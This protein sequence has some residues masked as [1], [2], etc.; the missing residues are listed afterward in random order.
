MRGAWILCLLGLSAL[1]CTARAPTDPA[2]VASAPLQGIEVGNRAPDFAL[3]D[4]DA[5]TM[6]LSDFRGKVVLLE[7]S[8][9]W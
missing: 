9:M 4:A 2:P 5:R 3:Q 7:F 8:A 1:S 6:R